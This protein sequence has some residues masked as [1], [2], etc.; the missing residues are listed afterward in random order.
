MIVPRIIVII[1]VVAL[2]APEMPATAMQPPP[3]GLRPPPGRADSTGRHVPTGAC[4]APAIGAKPTAVQGVASGAWRVTVQYVPAPWATAHVLFRATSPTGAYESVAV[5]STAGPQLKLQQPHPQQASVAASSV[6]QAIA[7]RASADTTVRLREQSAATTSRVPLQYDPVHYRFVD[8]TVGPGRTYFYRVAAHYQSPGG[9]CPDSGAATSAD[10]AAVATGNASL[11]NATAAAD[12][13]YLRVALAW[14]EPDRHPVDYVIERDGKSLPTKDRIQIGRRRVYY[15]TVYASRMA[16]PLYKI[17]AR[18]GQGIEISEQALTVVPKLWGFADLHVHQFGDALAFGS[19]PEPIAPSEI[20][21]GQVSLA[22]LHRAYE[23]GLRL[24]VMQAL[25]TEVICTVPEAA[26][27]ASHRLQVKIGDQVR[28]LVRPYAPTA[29]CDDE[30]AINRQL[31]AAAALEQTDHWYRIVHSGAEARR[32]IAAG[33]LAVVLGVEVDNVLGCRATQ[34]ACSASDV[35]GR[36]KDLKARGVRSVIPVHLA[37]NG[38]G[39]FALYNDVFFFNNLLLNGS[40]PAV[41]DCSEQ[42]FRFQFVGLKPGD[43]A[44]QRFGELGGT[45]LSLIGPLG[46]GLAMPPTAPIATCN[47]RGLSSLGTQFIQMLM[48]QRMLID[49]D[50]MSA[51]SADSTVK[52]ATAAEH[53]P[54]MTSH[55]GLVAMSKGSKIAEGQRTDAQVDAIRRFGGVLAVI[56]DQGDTSEI[57][58]YGGLVPNNCD[59]SSRSWA[60][61][62]LYAARRGDPVAFGSDFNGAPSMGPRFDESRGVGIG[63]HGRHDEALTQNGR[64]PDDPFALD[65][66]LSLKRHVSSRTALGLPD[67]NTKGLTHIGLYPEFIADLLQIGMRPSDLVPLFRSAEAFVAMWEKIDLRAPVP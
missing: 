9:A 67:F 52:L 54:L 11:T 3:G 28:N 31:A 47:A 34:P 18:Y 27:E 22:G 7:D 40:F 14:D 51:L 57:R 44:R 29:P 13:R 39:G 20:P 25:N 58:T 53:Y 59:A 64:V 4:V 50:H 56:V 24:I 17:T 46:S 43:W 48:E 19:P 36:L 66:D 2:C 45:V 38:Y 30:T 1:A 35:A 60:Q 16:P 10:P 61:V 15:D 41:R 55:S 65:E 21:R 33:N 6:R 49:I 62:Y 8:T 42:G 12:A 23:A 32:A 5:D 37:D 26:M 63:C